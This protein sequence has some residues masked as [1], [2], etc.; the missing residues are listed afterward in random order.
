PV[1]AWI[2]GTFGWRAAFSFVGAM[3]MLNA[4]WIYATMPEAVKPPG[5][6][7]SAWRAILRS[8]VLMSCLAVT[9]L[10]GSGQFTLYSYLAPYLKDRVGL[11]TGQFSTIL[12][13]FGVAGL[14]GNALM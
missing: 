11:S 5:L 1:G 12:M 4:A 14:T 13:W 10:V 3:G 8:P 6:S 9:L 2:G 7:F